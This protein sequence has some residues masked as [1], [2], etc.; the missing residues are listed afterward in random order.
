MPDRGDSVGQHREGHERT[1]GNIRQGFFS[2][3]MGNDEGSQTEYG[4]T[5]Q[6]QEKD[7]IQNRGGSDRTGLQS[8]ITDPVLYSGKRAHMDNLVR[9]YHR[10]DRVLGFFSSRPNWDSPT[11]SH[12]GEFPSPPLVKG[13]GHTRLRERGWGG[14]SSDE[15][16]DT[17]VL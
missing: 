11:P 4:R 3:R 9:G 17:L 6:G 13:E 12:G 5:A 8:N 10:V 7:S 2:D 16:T 15:G 1:G 14:P